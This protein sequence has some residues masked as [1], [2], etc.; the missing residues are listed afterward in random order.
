M[1]ELVARLI[2]RENVEKNGLKKEQ[3]LRN[4][5]KDD[6]SQKSA[7]KKKFEKHN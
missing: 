1:K 2:E 5:N 7:E 3:V 6:K 4:F